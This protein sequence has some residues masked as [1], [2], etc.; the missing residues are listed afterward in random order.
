MLCKNAEILLLIQLQTFLTSSVCL[1]G[2]SWR[3][4]NIVLL[5]VFFSQNNVSLRMACLVPLQLPSDKQCGL[6]S[7]G[8]SFSNLLQTLLQFLNVNC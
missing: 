8:T 1:S 6:T 5:L 4:P 3:G 2:A 7:P